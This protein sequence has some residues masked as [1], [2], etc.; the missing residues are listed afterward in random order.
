MIFKLLTI[1][2]DMLRAM[3]SQ[4]ILGRAVKSGAIQ[5]E[6]IDIRPFSLQKHKNTDDA[7]FGGGAGMVMLAQPVMDAV[8]YAMGDGFRGKRIYLSPKGSRFNQKKAEAL[9]KEDSL[10]L[11]CGHYEGLDQRAIDSCIDE[12]IS[13]GDY[14]LTGGELG[15]LIITDAVARLLPGVLGSDESSVDESFS[16]GLLEYPQYTRPR[17]IAGLAVPE[18]LLGGDQK[19]IDR[20]RRDEAVRLT[21]ERRREMLDSADLDREDRSLLRSLRLQEKRIRLCIVSSDRDR[22]KRLGYALREESEGLAE[23]CE[24]NDA[25]WLICL[26]RGVRVPEACPR[27]ILCFAPGDGEEA[28]GTDVRFCPPYAFDP[29][30]MRVFGDEGVRKIA[31]GGIDKDAFFDLAARVLPVRKRGPRHADYGKSRRALYINGGEGRCDC[32]FSDGT[33]VHFTLDPEP[34]AWVKVLWN[35]IC[36]DAPEM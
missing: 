6:V 5:A 4:S 19:K 8:K 9:A 3:L 24:P 31:F 35:T 20:W 10:I 25:E 1:F 30:L 16:S 33:E 12:E 27:R 21:F 17:E 28:N 23:L 29:E 14:V 22:A 11:L 13:V 18:V 32:A 15:A 26:D 2:P 34:R 36:G 7:P